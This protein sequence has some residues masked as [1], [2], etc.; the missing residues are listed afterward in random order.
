MSSAWLLNGARSDCH[1]AINGNNDTKFLLSSSQQ[2]CIHTDKGDTKPLWWVDMLKEYSVYWIRLYVRSGQKERMTHLHVALDQQPVYDSGSDI[3][4]GSYIDIHANNRLPCKGRNLTIGRT[5]ASDHFINICEVRV[6][7]CADGYYGTDCQY[8]CGHCEGGAACDKVIGH[9]TSCDSG[10][11]LVLTE[12]SARTVV[13]SVGTVPTT[14]HVTS[15][16]DIVSGVLMDGLGTCV[17]FVRTEP[18]ARTVVSSVG[19]V[20]TT[21]HVTSKTDIVRAVPRDGQETCAKNV[22]MVAMVKVVG[23]RVDTAR[24]ERRVTREM[25]IVSR[26]MEPTRCPSAR[27]M[28][29]DAVKLLSALSLALSLIPEVTSSVKKKTALDYVTLGDATHETE[30]ASEDFEA[31]YENTQFERTHD[32]GLE[33]GA[34]DSDHYERLQVQRGN[35]DDVSP[36]EAL[37]LPA[38][39]QGE[40]SAAKKPTSNS[41]SA[42]HAQST[43]ACGENVYENTR[44]ARRK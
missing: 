7:E 1:A 37:S 34:S 26:V 28:Q 9:C 2:N 22:L 15:K 35:Q 13:S 11:L 36:Y 44:F 42:N 14:S 19:T 27:K 3:P 39:Q 41:K 33:P 20:P 4:S 16:M 23:T 43:C 24:T 21:S 31:N 10:Y 6:W 25:D 5:A 8:T 17:K 30:P 32:T 38:G 40:T 29:V 12:H 18:T